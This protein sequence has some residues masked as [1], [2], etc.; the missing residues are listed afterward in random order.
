[1]AKRPK[2]LREIRE[3]VAQLRTLTDEELAGELR[4]HRAH[5]Y[6]LRTQ[7]VTEKV[8]DNSEFA[9]TRRLAARVLTEMNARRHKA[10][11]RA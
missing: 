10:A 1:M 11:A 3:Y 6:R 2:K 8:E 4:E 9:I 7:A 5:L